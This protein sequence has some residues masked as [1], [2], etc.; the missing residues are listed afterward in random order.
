MFSKKDEKNNDN[1]SFCAKNKVFFILKQI[2]KSPESRG[3]CWYVLYQIGIRCL[4][5][6]YTADANILWNYIRLE[7][8]V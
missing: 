6:T 8:D 4:A 5:A 3:F 2:I 7:L 1:E